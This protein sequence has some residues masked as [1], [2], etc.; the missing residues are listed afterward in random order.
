MQ[1]ILKTTLKT[2]GLV[3]D[4][5]IDLIETNELDYSNE[6]HLKHGI[7]LFDALRYQAVEE[8]EQSFENFVFAIFGND[9]EIDDAFAVFYYWQET[10]KLH[11]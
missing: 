3:L 11:N 5:S 4:K 8:H 6:K 1:T 9:A 10:I 2:I 7:A